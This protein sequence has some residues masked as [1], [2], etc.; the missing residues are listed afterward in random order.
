MSFKIFHTQKIK[1]CVCVCR[2]GVEQDW[3]WLWKLSDR[4]MRTQ[5]SILYCTCL[6]MSQ[7]KK[8]R[9]EHIRGA[10]QPYLRPALD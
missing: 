3:P 8:G 6:K 4:C 2:I 9:G 7:A 5:Y 10:M 1:V